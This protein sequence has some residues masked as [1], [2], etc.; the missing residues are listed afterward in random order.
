MVDVLGRRLDQARVA[1]EAEGLS[2][3]VAE[4]KS[5]RRVTHTGALRVVRQQKLPNRLVLLVVTHER[6]TP[7][8]RPPGG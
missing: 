2:V 1:L 7:A 6:F 5:P 4:T 3:E 8:S